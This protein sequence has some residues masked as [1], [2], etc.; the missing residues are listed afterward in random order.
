MGQIQRRRP[1]GY[2]PDGASTPADR[3]VRDLESAP[4]ASDQQGSLDDFCD[5]NKLHEAQEQEARCNAAK[6]KAKM[7]FWF[8]LSIAGVVAMVAALAMVVLH[9]L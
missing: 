5:V 6:A 7:W 4:L 1:T 3:P 8:F 2:C 9:V